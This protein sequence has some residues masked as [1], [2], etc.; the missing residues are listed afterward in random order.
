MLGTVRAS[1]LR[2]EERAGVM[3]ALAAWD[4]LQN[5]IDAATGESDS[6]DPRVLLSGSDLDPVEV[7]GRLQT[8][9]VANLQE[10]RSED[11]QEGAQAMYEMVTIAFS[12]GLLCGQEP[13]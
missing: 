2:L 9:A 6:Y 7:M 12:F 5:R 11:P 10:I 13:T 3:S 1:L 4:R 8:I